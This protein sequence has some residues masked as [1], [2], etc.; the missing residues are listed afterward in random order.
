MSG[1]APRRSS[2]GRA[3]R[4]FGIALDAILTSAIAWRAPVIS[5]FSS[6]EVPLSQS[7]YP[8]LAHTRST[9]A[10]A[11]ILALQFLG[12]GDDG[13]TATGAALD[14]GPE[15]TANG[16]LCGAMTCAS[17]QVCC[18]DCSGG[19]SCGAAC[20]GFACA[21]DAASTDAPSNVDHEA[22]GPAC[23]VTLYEDTTCQSWLDGN[24]CAYEHACDAACASIIACMNACPAPKTDACITNCLPAG[25]NAL[26]N[27]IADCSK[28]VIPPAGT[29]CSWP[30]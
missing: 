17:G 1:D 12:C 8:S 30:K 18:S 27:D 25:D 14:S 6:K 11:V 13:N 21:A 20:P 22:G 9:L 4:V 5:L 23:G 7:E 2:M 26:L 29:S 3:M 16:P 15:A 24:C 19:F 28:R 10:L